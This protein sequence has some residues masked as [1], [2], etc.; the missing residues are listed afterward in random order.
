MSIPAFI[1]TALSAICSPAGQTVIGFANFGVTTYTAVKAT[2]NSSRLKEVQ[3]TC[4]EIATS[5]KEIK[6]QTSD[7]FKI[8][9]MNDLLT[10]LNTP[11][12]VPAQ[13]PV[14]PAQVPA[15]APVDPALMAFLQQQAEAMKTISDAVAELKTSLTTHE[16][17]PATD[18][19]VDAS[20]PPADGDH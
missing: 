20:A 15:P 13:P 2:Q 17:A 11:P 5:A 7:L 4:Y 9:D 14:V 18:I 1:T 6:A 12:V 8:G 19:V 10:G 16:T 3:A